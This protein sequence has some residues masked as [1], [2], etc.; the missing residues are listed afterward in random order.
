MTDLEQ[1]AA[2]RTEFEADGERC[3][4]GETAGGR[5]DQGHPTR[6]ASTLFGRG[7]DPRR[8]GRAPR[9]GE[10]RRTLSPRGIASS[11]Y[12]GW[13]KEFLEA[14]KRR[15]AGDTAR[16]ATSD[17][18]KDLRREVQA[19]KEARIGAHGV[20]AMT[21]GRNPTFEKRMKSLDERLLA[22]EATPRVREDMTDAGL[23]PPAP[24]PKRSFLTYAP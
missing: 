14:G 6:D 15:L 1:E 24:P 2:W 18:V 20:A 7:E 10:H 12:Y 21:Q 23:T 4:A 19:L 3:C 13:S 5:R 8:A 22:L 17:E 16:A 11:M 9:R